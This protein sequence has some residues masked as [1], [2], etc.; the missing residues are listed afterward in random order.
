ML[1]R[2]VLYFTLIL[3]LFGS[4]S[5]LAEDGYQVLKREIPIALSKESPNESTVFGY[6]RNGDQMG[7]Q[8]SAY[9]IEAHNYIIDSLI[10]NKD[11]SALIYLDKIVSLWTLWKSKIV[12]IP[13]EHP[14]DHELPLFKGWVTDG[15]SRLTGVKTKIDFSLNDGYFFSELLI[16][17]RH[18]RNYGQLFPKEATRLNLTADDIDKF[19][20]DNIWSKWNGRG[21]TVAGK[22]FNEGYLIGAVTHM[23]SHFVHAASELL[24]RDTATKLRLGINNIEDA[25]FDL[26][27]FYS[28][29]FRE[30]IAVETN[31]GWISPIRWKWNWENP[32]MFP[33]T[34][35]PLNGQYPKRC[36]VYPPQPQF[37]QDVSHSNHIIRALVSTSQIK[38]D[39]L[40]LWKTSENNLFISLFNTIIYRENTFPRF[41][42]YVDGSTNPPG[43]P[44]GRM[45]QGYISGWANLIYPEQSTILSDEQKKFMEYLLKTY[46]TTISGSPT[47]NSQSY[48]SHPAALIGILTKIA[49]QSKINCNFIE[50]LAGSKT[51]G[52]F[53]TGNKCPIPTPTATATHTPTVI[54]ST[55]PSITPTSVST[56]IATPTA[57]FTAT[58]TPRPSNIIRNTCINASIVRKNV[59]STSRSCNLIK[60]SFIRCCK[61][62]VRCINSL[63]IWKKRFKARFNNCGHR[64]K[65]QVTRKNI[66][67][68]Y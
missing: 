49:A 54:P 30:N 44:F 14:G 39:D 34:G 6:A 7:L 56:P 53:A 62:S 46:L 4:V 29:K 36:I 66:R 65:F 17:S 24:K 47:F 64:I 12:D 68:Y 1:F 42:E 16:I 20:I 19:F 35:T 63:N 43:A 11:E 33:A 41:S 52:F 5:V 55:T 15:T 26:L 37:M 8:H 18:L 40:N 48:I 10:L 59:R 13:R 2:K 51:L 60:S 28:I 50:S 3:S 32:G 57:L 25:L 23:D 27:N 61:S 22:K 9:F 45:S 67:L 21:C 31:N 58:T 38:N